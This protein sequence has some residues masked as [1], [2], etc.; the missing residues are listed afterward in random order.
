M[1]NEYKVIFGAGATGLSCA[2]YFESEG[3]SY[4]VI[5]DN[6]SLVARQSLEKINPH[7][8]FC[9]ANEKIILGASEIVI[10]PGVALSKP[11]LVEAKKQGIPITGD[12]AMFGLLAN[13]PIVA[14]TGTNGKST[15]TAMLG[16]LASC[17][18]E[19]VSVGGNIG[20]PCLDLLSKS[21]K[22]YI[23]ELSSFQLELANNLP[24][25]ASIVLNLSP[26][27]LDRYN[28]LD[29]YYGVKGN[30]YRNCETAIINRQLQR[31]YPISKSS[32]SISFGLDEPSFPGD[33]GLVG[34][35]ICQ[36]RTKLISEKDLPIGGEHNVLNCMAALA[37]GASIGLE[38]NAMLNN[39]RSFEGLP[40]RCELVKKI[41]GIT[42]YNDSKAT[43]ISSCTAAIN[44]FAQGQNIILLLGGVSKSS[45]FSKL[46]WTVKSFVKK[47]IV[48]GESAEEIIIALNG[49]CRIMRVKTL[50]AA[51]AEAIHS[52]KPNDIVLLSPA[53]ASFDMF[54]DYRARG[55][56]FKALV[57]G[58]SK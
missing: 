24:V 9:E 12:A 39:L 52:A 42:F 11:Y 3:V 54:E 48:F 32:A 56:A 41:N 58:Y 13:A 28:S 2:R 26:D 27:H 37:L 38:M 40:H 33:F 4:V 34:R 46:T 31:K 1:S 14:I 57:H 35:T 49:L 50:A 10:S 29:H 22:L 19:G 5:D 7:V 55:N 23:L 43:N 30:I 47:V 45:D 51:V 6:P 25:L 18:R 8:L 20:K 16:H 21:A 53:C 17:Q 36:G 15:V 44:S